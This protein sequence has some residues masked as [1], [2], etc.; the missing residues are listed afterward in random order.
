L[1]ESKTA[2]R[3]EASA[4]TFGFVL[5]GFFGVAGLAM[6]GARAGEPAP[7]AGACPNEQ[8]AAAGT[9]V[10]IEDAKAKIGAIVREAMAKRAPC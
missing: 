4:T 5:A 1:R 3:N 9:C 6:D 8:V 7:T 10:A 2:I